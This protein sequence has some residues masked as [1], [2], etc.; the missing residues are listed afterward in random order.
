MVAKNF[1]FS[2]LLADDIM[3]YQQ[4]AFA[5]RLTLLAQAVYKVCDCCYQ[6]G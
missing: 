6:G 2:I 5:S 1:D 4:E 3:K